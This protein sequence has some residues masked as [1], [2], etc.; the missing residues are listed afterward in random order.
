MAKA[1]EEYRGFIT[2]A[3][4]IKAQK[5]EE[6]AEFSK[7]TR[8][9]LERQEKARGEI[10]KTREVQLERIKKPIQRIGGGMKKIQKGIKSLGSNT[11]AFDVGSKS[12]FGLGSS[13]KPQPKKKKGKTI[14]IKL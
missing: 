11:G 5:L 12:P 3:R 4:T 6:K 10:R 14:I 1:K 13:Q 9:L 2:K 7:K 8:K